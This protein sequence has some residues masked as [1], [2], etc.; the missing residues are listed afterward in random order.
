MYIFQYMKLSKNPKAKTKKSPMNDTTYKGVYKF[1]FDTLLPI[2]T[3]RTL[4]SVFA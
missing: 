1:K 3:Y 4:T 2:L